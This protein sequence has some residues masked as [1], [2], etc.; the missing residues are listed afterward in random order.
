MQPRLPTALMGSAFGTAFGLT[1]IVLVLK[2][3]G[4]RGT[5][6]ALA[7]TARF[8][9]LLFWVSY[10]GGAMAALFGPVF[11]PLKRHG[12]DFGIAFAAAHV[13]HIGLVAWLCYLGAVPS[14]A[15]LHF[16]RCRCFMALPY[17]VFVNRALTTKTEPD[18]QMAHFCDRA[19]LH[20]LR[21]RH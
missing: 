3:G 15:T 13:V 9:F 10:T 2:G 11:L 4:V 6:A 12:R 21:F 20:C 7:A 16:L 18:S 17:L 19:E 1:I 8:S 5:E 14:V